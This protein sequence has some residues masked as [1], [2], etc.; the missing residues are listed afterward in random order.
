M[1]KT[2]LL[3]KQKLASRS[4][5]RGVALIEVLIALL[6]LFFGI[7]GTVGMQG[8]ASIALSESR[9]RA[10][11]V[12]ATEKLIG[13]IW[14][15]QDHALE[16]A[17]TGGDPNKIKDWVDELQSSIPGATAEIKITQSNPIP[18]TTRNAVDITIGW[19]RRPDDDANQHKVVVFLESA[20]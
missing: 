16:Y 6:I 12:I 15:D 18:T 13:I 17:T 7:L 11:A 9:S 1:K 19:K 3:R 10:E 5:S 14:N 20:R 2:A 8:K 4:G